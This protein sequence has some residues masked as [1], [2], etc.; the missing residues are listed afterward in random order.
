MQDLKKLMRGYNRSQ[1]RNAMNEVFPPRDNYPIEEAMQ[2]LTQKLSAGPKQIKHIK[3][4]AN[5]LDIRPTTL[6]RAAA[7]MGIKKKS[8]GFGKNKRSWWSLKGRN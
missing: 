1:V 4:A 3:A 7:E 5:E 2:F 8:T 6:Y